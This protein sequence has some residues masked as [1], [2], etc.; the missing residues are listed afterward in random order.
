MQSAIERQRY[1][2]KHMTHIVFRCLTV[3]T[4]LVTIVLQRELHSRSRR[5]AFSE[6]DHFARIIITHIAVLSVLP[7]QV[8]ALRRWFLYE[9]Q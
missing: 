2:T 1:F 6:V 4:V 8:L 3:S 5:Y 7:E 9:L